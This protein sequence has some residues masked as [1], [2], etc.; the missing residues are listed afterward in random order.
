MKRWIYPALAVCLLLGGCGAEY[1]EIQ[2]PVEQ[3]PVVE[4]I[5]P[6]KDN[7]WREAYTE[8]LQ[9]KAETVAHLRNIDRVDYDPNTV[10]AEIDAVRGTY[11]LYDIDKDE[12][13]ELLFRCQFGWY[14]EFYGCQD[15]QA[16]LLGGVHSKDAAFY[17]WPE[18]NGVLYSWGRMGGHYADRICLVDGVL[19]QETVFEEGMQEPVME[20]TPVEEFL[21]GSEYLYE[22]RTLMEFPELQ[23]LTLPVWEYGLEWM[24][25]PIDSARDAAARTAIEKALNGETAFYGVSADGYGGDTGFILMRDYLAPG[26]VTEYTESPLTAAE[27]VWLDYNGDG[28]NE[29][30]MEVRHA[31]GD[32]YG[33]TMQVIF[34]LQEDT[35][36]AYCLNY[37]D[38]Y[39]ARGKS[40]FSVYDETAFSL[41]FDGYECCMFTVKEEI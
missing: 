32:P 4:V 41:T 38:S 36:Y 13:P 25:Q 11:M 22:N 30:R 31:E 12:V 35:V 7:K 26:G 40:F 39:E 16:V 24:A 18:G 1:T 33:G 9:E 20:Y 14:T 2:E 8:L 10:D 27:P 28:Q 6:A 34:S 17:S 21:P 15:G 29:A 23:A 5:P 19:V 37:M 3:Q